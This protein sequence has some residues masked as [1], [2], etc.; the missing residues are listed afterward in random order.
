MTHASQTQ[1]HPLPPPTL[2]PAPQPASKDQPRP[3]FASPQT[4]SDIS[5]AR[6]SSIDTV[7]QSQISTFSILVVAFVL[8]ARSELELSR[9]VFE[10]ETASL[11]HLAGLGFG[12]WSLEFGVCGLGFGV[13]GLGFGV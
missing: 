2:P 11:K 8:M 13:C 7:F 6:T 10:G 4:A 1:H 5:R 9:F 3:R 12:A